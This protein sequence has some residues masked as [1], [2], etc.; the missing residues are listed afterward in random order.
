MIRV[1]P[2][3]SSL[4][5]KESVE[6]EASNLLT[7]LA[8]ELNEEFVISDID[9]LY[10]SSFSLILVLSGGSEN[11]FLKNLAKLKPP[12]YLLTYGTNNSLAASLEILSYLKDHNLKGEVLHGDNLYLSKRI[13]ELKNKVN[14]G[15]IGKPSDWLISSL[16]NYDDVKSLYNINL[17]D[18]SIEE[19]IEA[20]NKIAS[21]G[22]FNLDYNKEELNKSYRL[23][24][25]LKEIVNKYNLKGFTIRCFDLLST[26]K[27]TACLSLAYFNDE[28]I[29]AT[30]EGDIPAMLSMYIVKEALNLPSFQANPARIDVQNQKMVF[31]HCTISFKMLDRFY[32]DTHY[33]SKIGVAIKGYLKEDKI[34]LFKLSSNLKDYYLETGK[35]LNSL[36]ET[37]LCRTQIEIKVD[38]NIDY[39]LK[40]PYGNHHLIVYGDHVKELRKYLDKFR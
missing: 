11:I 35:I 5:D 23:Y 9:H 33:E 4:H 17:I 27:T 19:V 32:L 37:N 34:T 1:L 3:C 24:L 30:C 13:K 31:A 39:F 38:N 28:G 6:K 40:R 22:S 10:D 26:L 29:I 20:Y 15:V 25:A 18:I 21:N 2:I 7:S 14:L 16:V 12:F 36:D 8:K